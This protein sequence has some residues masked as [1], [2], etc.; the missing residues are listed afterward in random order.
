MKYFDKYETNT[1]F[2]NL[3]LCVM[4]TSSTASHQNDLLKNGEFRI[5]S[6]DLLRGLVIVLMAI[7]HV[8]V[9]SGLPAGG[10]DP[11]IF[12]TRWITHFCAPAFAFFAGT[13]AFLYGIKINDPGK[14]ARYLLTRGLLLVVLELTLVKFFWTFS[15]NYEFTLAGVIW[16]LGWCM[17]ILAAFVKMKPATIGY[18]GLGIIFL[19]QAFGLIMLAI[20][21]GARKSFALF[22]EFIYP[23]GHRNIFNMEIL[24]VIVPWIGVMMAG[25]GFGNILKMNP[26]RRNKICIRIGLIAIALFIIV[27]SVL[28]L[29]KP[30]NPEGKPSAPFI[31]QLLNQAKYPASQLFLLMTLGPI[32]LLVPL[33]EKAKNGLAKVLIL[34]G[35]VP[36]FYYLAHILIIHLSALLVQIIREGSMH[37][38]WFATAPYSFIPPEFRWSLGLLY[39]VFI[40]DI[41]L[42][43]FL[44]RWYS[45]YKANN[46]NIKWLKFL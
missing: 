3:I 16:M 40:V 30:A 29:N 15:L 10:P 21:E 4:A 20:P 18:I 41:I 34:F 44:C 17:I 27:G 36:M 13:S 25:Y 1:T 31:F 23:T 14:L 8:R 28:I 38:E 37:P 22:W 35:K 7:D 9:Y 6:V 46:P 33:A 32:I 2:N 39:L 5:Q 42:L 43:Y 24:Y 19:Q 26:E 45:A 12:F 11:G